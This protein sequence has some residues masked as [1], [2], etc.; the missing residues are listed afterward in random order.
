MTVPATETVTHFQF[1][2]SEIAVGDRIFANVNVGG[3]HGSGSTTNGPE[4]QP[5]RID[6]TLNCGSDGGSASSSASSSSS[7]SSSASSSRYKQNLHTRQVLE[8]ESVL[9]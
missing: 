4:K 8:N 5:E 7:S 1:A 3:L 2:E 9:I 6:V